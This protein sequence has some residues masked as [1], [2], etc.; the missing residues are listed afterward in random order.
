MPWP[1]VS[2][3]GLSYN[4]KEYVSD[5]IESVLGQT[6][7]DF[8]LLA[9][10][11]GSTDGSADLLREYAGHPKVRLLE[12]PVHGNIGARFNHAIREARGDLISFLYSDDFYLES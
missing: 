1:V 12:F 2:V 5:A 10:D 11:N 8:E 7:K 9:V 4:Q 6:Y 3:I